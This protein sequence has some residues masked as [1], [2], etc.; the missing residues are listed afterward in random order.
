MATLSVTINHTLSVAEAKKRFKAALEDGKRKYAERGVNGVR[1][2]WAGNTL[3]LH[4]L[5]KGYDLQG[6]LHILGDRVEIQG[7]LP[8]VL[9]LWKSKIEKSI[10][11]EAKKIL[12]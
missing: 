1:E 12:R 2:T 10:I 3:T 8:F 5:I 11:H 9:S 7:E 4:A 6:E